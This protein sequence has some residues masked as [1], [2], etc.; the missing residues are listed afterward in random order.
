M[1]QAKL[2]I[3]RFFTAHQTKEKGFNTTFLSGQIQA[4][5]KE[6]VSNLLERKS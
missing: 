3:G 4:N 6:F 5:C 2:Q 1:K